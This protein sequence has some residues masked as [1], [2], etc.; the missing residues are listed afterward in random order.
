MEMSSKTGRLTIYW[1][2]LTGMLKEQSDQEYM[3][4]VSPLTESQKI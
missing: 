3:Y 4:I 2:E 1:G